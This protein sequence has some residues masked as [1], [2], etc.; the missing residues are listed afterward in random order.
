MKTNTDYFHHYNIL[1][2]QSGASQKEV[3]SAF[4]RLAKLCHPDQ[5]SSPYAEM[6]YKE[7]RAAYDALRNKAKTR[8]VTGAVSHDYAP[9]P[10]PSPP[11]H[12]DYGAAGKR[13]GAAPNY[14]TVCG[15]DWWYTESDEESDFEFGDLVGGYRA[16]KPPPK[17]LPFSLE[18]LPDIFRI[19]FNEVFGFLMIIRVFWASLAFWMM[20]TWLG[21]GGMWRSGMILCILLGVLLFRY[22]FSY[23]W[24]SHKLSVTNVVSSLLFSVALGYLCAATTEQTYAYIFLPNRSSTEVFP[25]L[26]LRTY[27]SLYLLWGNIY[28]AF[29]VFIIFS[30][31]L[32]PVLLF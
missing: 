10:P 30:P 1:G 13:H 4:R 18:N 23:H 11:P 5:D 22:Y 29:F 21:W 19:S 32:M 2:L 25:H 15:K 28:I 3:Q 12:A 27:I 8:L 20:F 16:T 7:I 14:R 26:I 31:I 9:P 6:R 17:R 24:Y